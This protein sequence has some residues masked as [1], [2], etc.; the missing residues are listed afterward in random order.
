MDE[1]LSEKMIAERTLQLESFARVVSNMVNGSSFDLTDSPK[2]LVGRLQEA[3]SAL[4]FSL[5]NHG[6]APVPGI[7][8]PK[9]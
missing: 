6:L 3:T 5:A 1:N 8:P 2:S 4:Q 7:L 9:S